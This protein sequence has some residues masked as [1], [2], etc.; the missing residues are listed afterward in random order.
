MV[1]LTLE[2]A[3]AV[4]LIGAFLVVS[5]GFTSGIVVVAILVSP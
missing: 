4:R 3:L 1:S 2:M 5:A